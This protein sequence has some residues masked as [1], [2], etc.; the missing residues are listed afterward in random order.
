MK[1]SSLMDSEHV[2]AKNSNGTRVGIFSKF[3]LLRGR[4][5]LLLSLPL[6]TSLCAPDIVNVHLLS[7]TVH[8]L[9]NTVVRKSYWLYLARFYEYSYNIL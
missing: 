1:L 7:N 9:S 2:R 8:L 3:N 6:L 4:C 5:T